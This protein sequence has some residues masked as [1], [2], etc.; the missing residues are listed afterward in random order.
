MFQLIVA[1]F[2]VVNTN[3]VMEVKPSGHLAV[4]E[5]FVTHEICMQYLDSKAGK[6]DRLVIDEMIDQK[7]GLTATYSCIQDWVLRG[8]GDSI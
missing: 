7:K 5:R 4:K 3:G 6:K 8:D 1:L 2:L